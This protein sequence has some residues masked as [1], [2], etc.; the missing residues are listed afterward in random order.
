MADAKASTG[1]TAMTWL[2]ILGIA[3]L[4]AV[5]LNIA[6]CDFRSAFRP[7]PPLT[8][9]GSSDQSGGRQVV[10]GKLGDPGCFKLPNGN[11]RC[12]NHFR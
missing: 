8:N 1:G 10:R 2:K 5:I 7:G 11:M 3:L 6:G 4:I 12:P 9:L